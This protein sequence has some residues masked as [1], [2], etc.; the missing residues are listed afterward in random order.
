MGTHSVEGMGKK[1]HLSL[2]LN[3]CEGSHFWF[4]TAKASLASDTNLLQ[5]YHMLC[6][7]KMFIRVENQ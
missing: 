4:G 7:D 2:A 1:C 3:A 5:K 6:N